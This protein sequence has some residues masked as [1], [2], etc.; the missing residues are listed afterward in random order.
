VKVV[1]IGNGIAGNEVSRFLRQGGGKTEITIIS[2][3]EFSEYDPCSLPYFIGGEVSRDAVFRRGMDDYQ[4][5]DIRLV[6][7][8][9]AEKID[10]VG[11]KVITTSGTEFPYDRL[12]L[13]HGGSLFVPPIPGIEK[14]GVLS[15]KELGQAD[16]LAQHKGSQAVVIGSGAIGIEAAEALKLKGYAVTIVELLDW[17]LPT[18]FC[19][20]TARRLETDLRGYG[21]EVLT[22]EKVEGIEGD[23]AVSAV[24]TN[25]RVLPCD[26]VVIATGVVPGRALAQTAGIKVN[27]GVL[28]NK[29][30][31]TS[32]TDIYAC[33]D[34][35]E[36]FDS[37]SGESCVYQ[38]KHNAIE[39][40]RVVARNIMGEDA[41]YG[42]AHAFA[43]AHFFDT[44][45]VSFG[46]TIKGASCGKDNIEVIERDYGRDY[47]RILLHNGKIIG[48]QAIG[49]C[50]DNIGIFMGAM[51]RGDDINEL[52]KEWKKV[53]H[54]E[55]VYP[56][57]YRRM[58]L[59][60][61]LSALAASSGMEAIE[62]QLILPEANIRSSYES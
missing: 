53:V 45:A 25:R 59:L 52:R 57:I 48:G 56:W 10:P 58:G 32:M 1:I 33:G 43:R 9:G 13:A 15:C 38:L 11:K 17:I 16:R 31:E 21:I 7:S 55:S 23:M 12:V 41:V 36:T 61:G 51:W 3:E 18:M 34:V 8:D 50:A 35:V 42:G 26:T 44:H 30:M 54:I 28:V 62:R 20:E 49:R 4:A 22:G 46:K 5:N 60:I 29:K 39:Q 6:L 14:K 47:L 24:V 27:R 2:A 40:A 19:E 37:S